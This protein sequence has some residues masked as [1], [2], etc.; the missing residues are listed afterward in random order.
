[1]VLYHGGTALGSA[2]YSKYDFSVSVIAF[3]LVEIVFAEPYPNVSNY[4][5]NPMKIVKSNI[6]FWKGCTKL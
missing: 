4:L 2:R 1:M 6:F 5:V 3:G